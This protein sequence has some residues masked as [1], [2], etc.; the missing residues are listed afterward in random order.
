[1]TDLGA[2]HSCR[3]RGVRIDMEITRQGL[4]D[5]TGTT[6]DT[7]S[8]VLRRWHERGL[9]ESDRRRVLIRDPH[10]LVAIAEDLPRSRASAGAREG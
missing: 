8:R 10:G 5:L 6:L 1:M 9:V 7:V 3:P 4:G 2:N